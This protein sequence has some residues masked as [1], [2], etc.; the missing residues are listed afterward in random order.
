[1]LRVATCRGFLL[2]LCFLCCRLTYP[3]LQMKVWEKQEGMYIYVHLHSYRRPFLNM[4]TTT[5]HTFCLTRNS[6]PGIEHIATAICFVS[7]ETCLFP[8]IPFLDT[9]PKTAIL[10]LGFCENDCEDI[11]PVL[12]GGDWPVIQKILG[13]FPDPINLPEWGRIVET[14][15]TTFFRCLSSPSRK[16]GI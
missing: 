13:S 12:G 1:M 3:I 8:P 16:L 14:L 11:P 2:E 7:L 5:G 9:T 10:L 4:L 15:H 6:D